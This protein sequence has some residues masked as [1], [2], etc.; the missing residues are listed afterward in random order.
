VLAEIAVKA[1]RRRW[2]RAGREAKDVDA[3][4]CAAPTC[5]APIRPW[6]SRV[7]E[8]LGIE[9]FGFDM[10]VACSSATFGIQTR[11]IS[12]APAMPV[13]CWWSA[14]KSAPATS[15]ERTATATSFSAMSRPPSWSRRED[16]GAC[17]HWEI[18]GTRLKTVFSNNIRNNFGFLNRAAPGNDRH[19]GQ[20]VRPG[21]PQGVQG[22]GADGR[23]R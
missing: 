3:V 2:Q 15:T 5:S 13:R 16:M 19:A 4:L 7:Q 12:S 21:R 8:A 1:A 11:P 14:R 10:N 23:A 9:G 17:A 6:R 18:L 22:S 20:A